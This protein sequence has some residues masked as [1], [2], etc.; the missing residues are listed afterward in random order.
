MT[1]IQEQL[2]ILIQLQD[3]E[4]EIGH[5][6]NQIDALN[7]DTVALDQ[8]CATQQET[9][10]AEKEALE[11]IKKA[12][13]ELETESSINDEMIAKSNVKLR[14]VSTNKEYQSILKE[15]AELEEKRSEMEDRMIMQLDEMD[16]AEDAISKKAAQLSRLV[17]STAVEKKSIAAKVETQRERIDTLNQQKAEIAA[18]VDQ[19][20]LAIMDDVKKRV[21]GLAV[22]PA[23]QEICTGCHMN[24]PPQLYNELQRFDELRFCPHCRRIVYWSD[25]DK[26]LRSE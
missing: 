9:V 18:K 2:K 25:K 15:I 10:E 5:T 23:R 17:E 22:V 21:R 4:A 6:E 7:A 19:K 11:T 16:A 14:E 1:P 26:K 24:I 12:Y 13:R 8:N 20:M 3:V